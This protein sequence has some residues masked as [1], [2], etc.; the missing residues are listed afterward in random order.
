[1]VVDVDGGGARMVLRGVKVK[2]APAFSLDVSAPG[3]PTVVGG[4]AW[5]W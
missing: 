1:V 5:R 3:F 4:R 2:V